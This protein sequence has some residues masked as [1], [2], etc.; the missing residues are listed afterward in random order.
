VKAA[1]AFL[2]RRQ[3]LIRDEV[4]KAAQY[5]P[6]VPPEVQMGFLPRSGLPPR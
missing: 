1:I 6:L 2:K 4:L 3:D 5:F